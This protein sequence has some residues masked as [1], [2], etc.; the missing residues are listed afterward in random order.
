MYR[1]GFLVKGNDLKRCK[2][3]LGEVW[4]LGEARSGGVLM[5]VQAFSF[6][7]QNKDCIGFCF[8]VTIT[9][10]YWILTD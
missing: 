8:E 4:R 10:W 7:E 9:L 6:S 2:M 1:P 5:G 3:N